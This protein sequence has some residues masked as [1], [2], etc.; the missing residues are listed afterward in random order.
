MKEMTDF[1]RIVAACQRWTEQQQ[2]WREDTG[3]RFTGRGYEVVPI[4]S[5]E[6][7]SEFV[8]RHHYSGSYVSA[9]H[10]FGLYRGGD[11][12]GVAV[13]SGPMEKVLTCALPGLKPYDESVELGRFV[14][15]DEV[16]GNAESWFLARCHDILVERGVR[17]VVSFSDPVAR[18]LS[19]G[20]LVM[21]GHVG[22]IYQATNGIYTGETE[23]RTWWIIPGGRVFN[24][25]A[26]QKIRQ[27][28]QG[29]QYAERQLVELGA[30]PMELGEDPKAWLREARQACKIT[31]FRHPGLHRYVFPLGRKAHHRAKV[32]IGF[33][34]KVYPKIR[35]T[36]EMMVNA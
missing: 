19:S 15:L 25:Q 21:P 35:S 24:G 34:A 14:L 5:D 13:Y 17:G 31:Y 6:V 10:R 18:R 23:A 16:P 12:V 3:R 26:L 8:E 32:T 22:T 29:H 28:K 33:P 9:M 30:R 4:D 27:Q 2:S 7:A 1:D 36:K 20:L 11:L